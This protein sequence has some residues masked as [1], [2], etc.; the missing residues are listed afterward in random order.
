MTKQVV[1][2]KLHRSLQV[3]ITILRSGSDLTKPGRKRH[4]KVAPCGG[5]EHIDTLNGPAQPMRIARRLLR[6]A[7]VFAWHGWRVTALF[8]CLQGPCQ[9]PKWRNP[10][11]LP[12]RL[13]GPAL[14]RQIK[15]NKEAPIVEA[16]NSRTPLLNPSMSRLGFEAGGTSPA[17][18]S[19]QARH[20][21]APASE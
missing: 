16:E 3:N 11:S 17:G 13:Q 21:R 8:T 4:R 9:S 2:K 10:G 20:A 18:R 1:T 15:K 14:K 7:P 6:V 19:G 5:R 12:G